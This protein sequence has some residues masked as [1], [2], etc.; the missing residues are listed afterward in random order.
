MAGVGGLSQ[1]EFRALLI[2]KMGLDPATSWSTSEI[3]QRYINSGLWLTDFNLPKVAGKWYGVNKTYGASANSI[4]TLGTIV[5]KPLV[6]DQVMQVSDLGVNIGVVGSAANT[7]IMAIYDSVGGIPKN[8]IATTAAM[9]TTAAIG[10][11]SA[12]LTVPVSLNPGLYWVA[13]LCLTGG[14]AQFTVSASEGSDLIA[15]AT[16][17]EINGAGCYSTAGQASLPAVAGALTPLNFSQR[18]FYKVAA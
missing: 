14:S 13:A 4:V 8:K 9:D 17:T 11:L 16:I 5:Y 7:L 10:P 15:G 3:L 18:Y 2:D 6:V 1:T 12:P